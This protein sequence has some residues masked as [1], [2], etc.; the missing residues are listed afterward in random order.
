MRRAAVV[1]AAVSALWAAEAGAGADIACL[2]GPL[3]DFVELKRDFH[4]RLAAMVDGAAPEYADLA[5]LAGELQAVWGQQRLERVRHLMRVDPGRL[6]DPNALRGFAW[7]EADEAVLAAE[8]PAYALLSARAAE[9]EAANDGHPG[10][11]G[12]RAVVS[13]GLAETPEY[14]TLMRDTAARNGA[15]AAAIARCYGG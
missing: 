12:L 5:G 2:E 10:W 13:E 4:G 11:P 9:L 14:K 1:L 7:T 15:I 6:P 3:G 8:N